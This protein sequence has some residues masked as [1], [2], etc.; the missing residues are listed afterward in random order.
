MSFKYLVICAIPASVTNLELEIS[1]D[2]KFGQAE[3]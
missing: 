1:I 3:K 2:F